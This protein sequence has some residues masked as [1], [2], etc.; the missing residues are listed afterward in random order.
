MFE[1]PYAAVVVWAGTRVAV[2]IDEA[3]TDPLVGME[4][5]DGFELKI[6][7]ERGGEVTITRLR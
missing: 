4:R 2:E 3:P 5:L 6:R 7:V 1:E